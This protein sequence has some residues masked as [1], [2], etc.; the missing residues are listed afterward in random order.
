MR[1][2]VTLILLSLLLT[3]CSSIPL[4]SLY[5]LSKLDIKTINPK[6]V[7][8]ALQLPDYLKLGPVS[9]ILSYTPEGAIEKPVEFKL[10]RTMR[11]KEYKKFEKNGYYISSY[12]L[13][14]KDTNTL[15][16]FR[17]NILSRSDTHNTKHKTK[18]K[19]KYQ[20]LCR[21]SI[22]NEKPILLSVYLK[23]S[24]Q[25][26]FFPLSEDIDIFSELKKNKPKL[27]K[28]NIKKCET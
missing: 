16:K 1:K 5:K 22:P 13:T 28:L 19:I 2:T 24:N 8:V 10:T 20:S 6:V 9:L 15:I 26:G 18:I 12:E 14:E 25:S 7:K 4:T 11:L 21:E 23:T 3:A 17:Q 27:D